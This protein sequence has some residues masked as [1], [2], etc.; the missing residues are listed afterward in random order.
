MCHF[1]STPTHTPPSV[2]NHPDYYQ[3]TSAVDPQQYEPLHQVM[4]PT[5]LQGN[6]NH[7]YPL[8]NQRVISKHLWYHGAIPRTKA[9]T[10]VKEDGDFLIRDSISQKGDF[11]LTVCWNHS[12]LHFMVNRQ[13]VVDK[14]TGATKVQYQFEDILCDSVPQLISRYVKEQKVISEASQARISNPVNRR[15]SA[16]S[17]N[18]ILSS[19][20]C[21]AV[22]NTFFGGAVS[23]SSSSAFNP[24]SSQDVS[25]FG[26][27]K[28]PRRTGSQPLLSLDDNGSDGGILALGDFNNA[29]HGGLVVNQRNSHS[30]NNK[31][32]GDSSGN[33]KTT[34][35][36]TLIHHHQN[37]IRSDSEPMISLKKG[38]KLKR[39]GLNKS[40]ELVTASSDSDLSKPPP[41]K[42]S[43]VPTVKLK[44]ANKKPMVAIRNKKLYDDEKDYSDYA[45]VKSWPANVKRTVDTAPMLNALEDLYRQF[46]TSDGSNTSED[47]GYQEGNNNTYD[48]V[49][50][51]LPESQPASKFN[52]ADYDSQ[53]L[54]PNNKPLEG[55]AQG[56]ILPMLLEM[57][58]KSLALHSTLLDL[59][60]LKVIGNHDLGLGV[61]SGLELITLPHGSQLRKDTLER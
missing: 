46:R 23:S 14:V 20:G 38:S 33:N 57:E 56:V 34:T 1:R 50:I 21:A 32:G 3:T 4:T 7:D 49:A 13:S 9:E 18:M 25:R 5:G 51:K 52:L 41:P 58:A 6:S 31:N 59:D 47:S 40:Q 43:R 45:A 44:D 8:H 15:I 30:N 27:D 28:R 42:P 54:T 36:K 22:N 2:V 53:I 19:P 16:D 61:K 39:T 17:L 48:P 10:L 12:P 24:T 37:H 11:V 55:S 60:L 26:T 35:V 29:S